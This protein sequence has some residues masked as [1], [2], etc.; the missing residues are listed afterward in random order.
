MHA[1]LPHF[2]KR[3]SASGILLIVAAALAMIAA[4][5]PLKSPYDSLLQIPA[6][7]QFGTFQI[8]KPLL[9]WIN[10]GLLVLFFFL[11]GL[12]LKR[13]VLEGELSDTAKIVLPP[14][15]ALGGMVM[16]IFIYWWCNRDNWVGAEGWAIP[17]ATDTAFALGV[18]ALLGKRAPLSLKIFLVSLATFDDI[19]AI[20]VVALFFT[21]QLSAAMLWIAASCLAILFI[22]H[23]GGVSAMP[24][25]VL[26][27]AVMWTAVLKSEV[28]ATLAGVLLAMF[29]PLK[30]GNN[31]T[32]SHSVSLN[33]N[34]TQPWPLSHCRC[35]LF[36]IR[37]SH[38]VW[39]PWIVS[40]TRFPSGSPWGYSS[41]SRL[42]SFSS[43]W[44][45]SG[46]ALPTCRRRSHH[47]TSTV[48]PFYAGLALP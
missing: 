6:G 47:L 24:P 38:W 33:R 3:E 22:L 42:E 39:C 36:S 44:L 1:S 27:G 26:V 13:G 23:R 29:I 30:A 48:P 35:L 25:Y 12:E 37:G 19:G 21:S 18:L 5:S 10:D 41:A 45:G 16:P 15:G 11:V 32:H 20:V 2:F 4:N 28:H 8:H 34:S 17:M 31:P 7:I 43:A 46:W 9:L 40:P 14:L